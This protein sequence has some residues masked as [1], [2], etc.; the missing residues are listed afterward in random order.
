MSGF[1]DLIRKAPELEE[2]EYVFWCKVSSETLAKL[3]ELEDKYSF[4]D[5][6]LRKATKKTRFRIKNDGVVFTEKEKKSD[7]TNIE[8]N[9]DVER[10]VA[11]AMVN[12]SENIHRV[13]RVNIPITRDGVPMI[14]KSDGKPLQWEIDVFHKTNRGPELSEWIKVELEVDNFTSESLMR[15]IPFETLEAFEDNKDMSEEDKAFVSELWNA[16]TNIVAS[17][18]R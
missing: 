3:L 7:G 12:Y 6:F 18:Y 1:S 2:R 15:L 10:A 8:N 16:E 11:M 4:L 9:Y 17:L 14:K 5:V 13:W